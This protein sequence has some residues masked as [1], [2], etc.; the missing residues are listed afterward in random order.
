M[1]QNQGLNYAMLMFVSGFLLNASL[2][3]FSLDAK[4]ESLHHVVGEACFHMAALVK[5]HF[6]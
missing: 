4:W 5:P 1:L 2:V 6:C 3:G